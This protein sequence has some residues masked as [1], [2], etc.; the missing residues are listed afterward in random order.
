MSRIGALRTIIQHA[1]PACPPTAIRNIEVYP[2][3]KAFPAL[4]CKPSPTCL[5]TSNN[6]LKRRRACF[7]S[8]QN[9]VRAGE[10]GGG[11]GTSLEVILPVQ[12]SSGVADR[13]TRPASSL[14]L[15][16][17]KKIATG[18]SRAW[19]T[20]TNLHH[21]SFYSADRAAVWCVLQHSLASDFEI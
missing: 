16:R 1:L 14:P 13:K 5:T 7:V 9:L 15:P 11:G 18:S 12:T 3:R 19:N 8:Y 21:E 6:A 20:V 4:P 10:G 2:Q 17:H